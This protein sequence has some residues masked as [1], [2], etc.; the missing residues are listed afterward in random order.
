MVFEIPQ[1][2]TLAFVI[3]SLVF[4]TALL[5]FTYTYIRADYECFLR[6]GPGALPSTPWGYLKSCW[7]R[8]LTLP[9]VFQP[10]ALPSSN[11]FNMATWY[12][13]HHAAAVDPPS[14]A[15][16]RTGN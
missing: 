16:R 12:H 9:D 4:D 8:R 11:G 15:S 13:F 3:I 10:P 6:L 5:H 2:E 14:T 1:T 7:L